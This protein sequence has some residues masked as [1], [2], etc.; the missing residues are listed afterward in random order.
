ML[1]KTVSYT[2]DG[3]TFEAFVATKDHTKRSLVLICH[4]WRGRDE[5]ACQKAEELAK[6]GYVGFAID[7]YGKGVQ[8]K[9]NEESALLMNPLMENRKLLRER[10]EIAYETARGLEG[11]DAQN[12]GVIGFCFGGLCAL[13]LA[14]SGKELKG[15]VSFHGLLTP[16]EKLPTKKIHAKLLVLH[17]HDDPMVS[18]EEIQK[19]QEEMTQNKVDWQMHI[20]GNTTHA[21]TNP[22]A[23]DPDFGTVYNPNAAKRSWVEMKDFFLEVFGK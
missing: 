9:N 14:R 11:V 6:L 21:F 13:D 5:F 23:N 10:L 4:A 12:M 1:T 19:F 17:G 15:L 16:P 2:H 3:K 22:L 8:G 7:L 18:K 20:Y